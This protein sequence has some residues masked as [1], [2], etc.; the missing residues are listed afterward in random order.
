MVTSLWSK[1]LVLDF[2]LSGGTFDMFIVEVQK[3][4]MEFIAT[5]GNII[6]GVVILIL[7]LLNIWIVN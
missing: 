4:V 6:L 1:E 3:D 7:R 2:D 5:W